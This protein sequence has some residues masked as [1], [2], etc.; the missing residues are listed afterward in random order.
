MAVVAV[1]AVVAVLS[2]ATVLGAV[3]V[4]AA[5]VADGAVGAESIVGDR[6]DAWSGR[7]SLSEFVGWM[8]ACC[9]TALSSW[10]NG[11]PPGAI[12]MTANAV[13]APSKARIAVRCG[14]HREWRIGCSISTYDISAQATVSEAATA[15]P[16]TVAR[17][18][19]WLRNSTKIGQWKRYSP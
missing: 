10:R 12:A 1:V 2:R 15:N 11:T 18:Q 6:G 8:S 4:P 13:A 19:P 5:P 7:S 14:F 3:G 9:S 17:S 16:Q